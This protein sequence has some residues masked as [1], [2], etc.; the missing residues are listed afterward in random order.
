MRAREPRY[1]AHVFELVV[2]K[3]ARIKHE[4]TFLLPLTIIGLLGLLLGTL[5]H[6]WIIGLPTL[7]SGLVG[8]GWCLRGLHEA[9]QI[10]TL[11]RP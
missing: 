7:I 3:Q 11:H 2:E 5:C 6:A 9:N 10:D 4:V 1:D 8:S